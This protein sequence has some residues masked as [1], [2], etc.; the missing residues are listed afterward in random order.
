ML[1]RPQRKQSRKRGSGPAAPLTVFPGVLLGD[2]PLDV[3][4]VVFAQHHFPAVADH[5]NLILLWQAAEGAGCHAA[6]VVR[7]FPHLKIPISRV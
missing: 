7:G 5:F 6:P 1:A 4:G 2:D 3:F